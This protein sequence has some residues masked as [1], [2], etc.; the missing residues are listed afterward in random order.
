MKVKKNTKVKN[1]AELLNMSITKI[2]TLVDPIIPKVCLMALTGTSD[3][4]KSTMLL[5]LCCD[6]ALNDRFLD[7][8]IN[9]EHKSAI[10][11]STEDDMYSISYR[12]QKLKG[13]D[14]EKL[15]N[16]RFIFNS[17]NL[18]KTID[19]EL[20]NQ[21]ADVVVIDTFT[22]VYPGE[23]N[24]INK[25]RTFMNDYFNLAIKHQ[26]LVIFNH[27]TGKYTE[28][29]PPSKN[30]AIGSAGFEGKARVVIELRPDY[31]GSSKKH[32]CIVKGNY[33]GNE[34]KESSF[35]LSFD[36]KSGFKRTGIR[37][38]FNL[39]AKP[40]LFKPVANRDVEKEMA[41]KLRKEKK[42]IRT[43]ADTLKVPK[44]TVADW[45]RS[46]SDQKTA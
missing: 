31:S 46:M 4:G 27:H 20:T 7:F 17:D 5:Q 10:Y 24:Q 29:K 19:S 41:L 34:Y 42:S 26:C 37:T 6:I 15:K 45:V 25:V 3:I 38:D 35:E 16:M 33:L 21:K 9:A 11:V 8:P 44:S 14:E 30:N 13:C 1:G 23:M 18:V 43:I 36:E 12:L 32:F 22:D 28:E 40:K 39:L 2:P